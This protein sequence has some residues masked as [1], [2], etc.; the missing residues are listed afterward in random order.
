MD[1]YI[2][3]GMTLMP[4]SDAKGDPLP[5]HWPVLMY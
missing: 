2:T 3:L 5:D 4:L 1:P